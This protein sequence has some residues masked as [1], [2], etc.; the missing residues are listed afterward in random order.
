MAAHSGNPLTGVAA[1]PTLIATSGKDGLIKAW[2][3]VTA[4]CV[5]R[6]K[7]HKGEARAVCIADISGAHLLA[8]AGRDRSVRLWDVRAG[9][10]NAIAVFAG[11]DGH[12]GW[13]HDVTMCAGHRP[14]ILSC[15]GDKMVRIWDLATLRLEAVRKGHQYRVWTVA[16]APQGQFAV[17]GSTDSTV[18]FWSLDGSDESDNTSGDAW[19]GHGDSVLAVSVARD[20]SFAI[21]ASEN[22]SVI[23]W[24]IDRMRRRTD[25][26]VVDEFVHA[27]RPASQP[28]R[29]NVSPSREADP[30][31]RVLITATARGSPASS[32]ETR[33]SSPES[34]DTAR[35]ARLLS[36]RTSRVPSPRS[37]A[38]SAVE[39]VMSTSAVSDGGAPTSPSTQRTTARKQ[40][41]VPVARSPSV[42][43]GRIRF[44]EEQVA[45][46]DVELAARDA[47]LRELEDMLANRDKEVSMLQRQVDSA[48]NLAKQAN[49]RAFS[50][51]TT[52]D[53]EAQPH[54]SYG[55]PI[56]RISRVTVQLKALAS[57]LD[58]MSL[59]S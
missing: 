8:S 3:P 38:R 23:L 43:A 17:S 50:A 2:D 15:G 59:L 11:E 56:D 32:R 26:V 31:P 4:T 34:R 22:G 16:A 7:G 9:A 27:P 40:Q 33:D 5:A 39:E 18:R 36:P 30:P 58:G 13:V 28:P 25:Q 45:L 10:A 19:E 41:L 57:K 37:P 55:E 29:A 54:L 48:Q 47:R 52:T 46:R 49:V 24:D 53:V 1:S 6:L 12:D 21:S 14:R 44:L 20:A 35:S 51:Q 42:S